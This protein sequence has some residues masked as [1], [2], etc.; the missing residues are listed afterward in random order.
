MVTLASHRI[1]ASAAELF[2]H[3][4]LQHVGIDSNPKAIGHDY[5]RSTYT[6]LSLLGLLPV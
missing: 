4:T 1:A 3:L 5:N 2:R 6:V